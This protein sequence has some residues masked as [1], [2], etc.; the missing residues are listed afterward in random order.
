MGS[1]ESAHMRRLSGCFARKPNCP[2]AIRPELRIIRPMIFNWPKLLH[3]NLHEVKPIIKDTLTLLAYKQALLFS[4][5]KARLHAN[6]SW[7]LTF[8]RTWPHTPQAFFRNITPSRPHFAREKDSHNTGN[9]THSSFPIIID[10]N[11]T[12]LQKHD[13]C[14][15]LVIRVQFQHWYIS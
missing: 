11:N 4:A 8:L 14:S 6:V 15:N 2:T 1:K 12:A 10:Y 3:N 5:G 9:F 7:L 13:N